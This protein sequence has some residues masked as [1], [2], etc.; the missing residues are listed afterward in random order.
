MN[1]GKKCFNLVIVN[2]TAVS[3]E[4]TGLTICRGGWDVTGGKIV[5]PAKFGQLRQL[6][7]SFTG[8]PCACIDFAL[9]YDEKTVLQVVFD[10]QPEGENTVSVDYAALK[11]FIDVSYD[12]LQSNGGIETNLVIR[13]RRYQS[14]DT[15]F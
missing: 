2:E 11:P 8:D 12:L 6:V 13:L 4:S 1:P 10:C 3:L 5:P 15:A 14:V 7:Y 9:Q